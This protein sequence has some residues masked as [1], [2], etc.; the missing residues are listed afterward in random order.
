M[1][2]VGR[3]A[4]TVL[5]GVI[6]GGIALFHLAQL[7]GPT[8]FLV[9]AVLAAILFLKRFRCPNCGYHPGFL[10][11]GKMAELFAVRRCPECNAEL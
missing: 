1:N 5:G 4:V 11:F 3:Q 6:L 10:A 9:L 8:F 7:S 2:T